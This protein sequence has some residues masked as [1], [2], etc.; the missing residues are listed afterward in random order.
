M[1]KKCCFAH[2]FNCPCFI[3]FLQEKVKEGVSPS[4]AQAKLGKDTDQLPP[5]TPL[6]QPSSLFASSDSLANDLRD[7]S[8]GI[9]NESQATVIISLPISPPSKLNNFPSKLQHFPYEL[10]HIPSEL[11]HISSELNHFPSELYHFSSE[12]YLFPSELYH[13]PSKL[14]PNMVT[15]LSS[16]F[17]RSKIFTI[18]EK[19]SNMNQIKQMTKQGEKSAALY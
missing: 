13:F 5:A 3:H 9:W 1:K 11:Y 14:Y 8:D 18:K 17:I 6:T 12:L 19:S 4:S 15:I 16:T 10:N 7:H 2:I